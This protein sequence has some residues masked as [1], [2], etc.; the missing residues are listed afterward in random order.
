MFLQYGETVHSLL[1][2]G[3]PWWDPAHLIF[4]GIFYMAL[5]ALG[6][7]LGLVFYKTYKDVQKEEEE[8]ENK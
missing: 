6:L 5:G 1:P 3:F 2:W 8:N 7:G 4:L